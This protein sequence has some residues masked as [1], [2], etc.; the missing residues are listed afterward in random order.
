MTNQMD[1]NAAVNWANSQIGK[2]D[3][4]HYCERFFENAYGKTG[5]YASARDYYNSAAKSNT[6]QT[7]TIPPAGAAVF[8]RGNPQFGHIALSAGNGYVISSGIG[9]KVEKVKIS[10]MGKL[11]GAEGAYTGWADPVGG[12][13]GTGKYVASA[14]T[15]STGSTGST[16]GTRRSMFNLGNAGASAN[17]ATI[18]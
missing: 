8:F 11:W 15:G 7:G 16:G 14:D 1:P 12:L 4:D 18:S 13:K 6:L 10:D 9:G 3:Y 5:N 2:N 17:V